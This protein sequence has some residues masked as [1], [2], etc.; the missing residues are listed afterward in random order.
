MRIP[1]LDILVQMTDKTLFLW[2][3]SSSRKHTAVRFWLVWLHTTAAHRPVQVSSLPKPLQW[4]QH[5]LLKQL[6]LLPVPSPDAQSVLHCMG[7]KQR[8][9]DNVTHTHIWSAACAC[10]F[11]MLYS[12]SWLALLAL[13]EEYPS[14]QLQESDVEAPAAS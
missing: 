9:A 6:T 10:I 5:A 4:A 1:M 7:L 2:Y 13:V 12:V 11:C 14:N 3:P 8:K